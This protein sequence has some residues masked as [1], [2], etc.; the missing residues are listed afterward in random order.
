MGRKLNTFVDL[1]DDTGAPFSF[2]P[3]DDLPSWAVAA[4]RNKSV[5]DDAESDA[6]T[7]AETDAESDRPRRGRP[8]KKAAP[9]A[10]TE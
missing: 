1:R 7:D 3:G 5:F 10:E 2:G 8:A 4:I 9:A 6:E